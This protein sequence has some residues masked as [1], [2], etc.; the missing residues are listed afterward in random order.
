M[1]NETNTNPIC[2]FYAAKARMQSSLPQVVKGRGVYGKNGE[3]R[4][5]YA[6]S[7]DILSAAQKALG[8]NGFS[9]RFEAEPIEGGWKATVYLC[10]SSGHFESSSFQCPIDPAPMMSKTHAA[11]SAESYARRVALRN[12]LG[13]SISD[14]TDDAD[15][16]E[17]EPVA[18]EQK[19]P[20]RKGRPLGRPAPP[21]D[22][23]QNVPRGTL[24]QENKL[25]LKTEIER[26]FYTEGDDWEMTRDS[27]VDWLRKC[28]ALREDQTLS[29]VTDATVDAIIAALSAPK[30]KEA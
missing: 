7:E 15:T 9:L 26:L 11:I 10:H 14:G 13:I 24:S 6:N 23:P 17:Q 30:E 29:V 19:Q 1:E 12:V 22:V 3:I 5:F 27:A 8:E 4:F 18:P 20:E 2:S 25:K 28:G 16:G 21:S